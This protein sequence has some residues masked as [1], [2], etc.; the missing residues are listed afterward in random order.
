MQIIWPNGKVQSLKHVKPNQK[1]TLKQDGVAA[2]RLTNPANIFPANTF[3]EEDN[4]G[5]NF[6]HKEND[7]IDFHTQALLPQMYSR[8][9]PALACADINN[10]LLAD[11]YVGGA[12]NQAGKIFIQKDNGSYAEKLLSESEQDIASEDVDAVFFDMDNDKDMD[13]YV[14]T[15]GYEFNPNNISLED[16]LYENDGRGNLKRRALPSIRNSGS[17]AR[18]Q[19]IDQD[20]DLDLFIGGRIVPG[21]YPETPE[22]AILINDGKGNFSV[23]KTLAESLKSAGMV[24][25]AAW[26]DL[27][28]DTYSDLV[29]VGEWMPIKIFINNNGQLEDRTTDYFS[30]DTHGFWNCLVASDFDRDGDQDLIAGNYGLNHQMKASS[31]H[32]VIMIYSDYDGNGSVDPLLNYFIG[33]KSYPYPSRDELTEQLPSFKKRFINYRSYADA[34]ITDM[35]SEKEFESSDKLRVILLETS[36]LKNHGDHL[37]VIP[38]PLHL[39]VA[40]VFSMVAADVNNDGDMDVV[41]G[42]N[43]SATRARSGKLTG[44]YGI[45]ALGNGKGGFTIVP[46]RKT[47]LRLQGDVRNMVYENG[48]LLVGMNN[49]RVLSYRLNK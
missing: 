20:G 16:K 22:S 29:V 27:N 37:E 23:D 34:T 2:N 12:K 15:G 9:G 38:M 19:D 48:K 43:L 14:V 30:T 44:N 10:D 17:C 8:Q 32:P 4:N 33:D 7:F 28:H 1:I 11:V 45:I 5:V 24:S 41:T 42:G 47:G 18:P 13:L 26:L 25:D 6:V 21:R 46:Q 39:Q 3:F 49:E 31:S 40:P 35:L 36:Y